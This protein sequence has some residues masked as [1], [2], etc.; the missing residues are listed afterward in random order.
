MLDGSVLV[1]GD[2]CRLLLVF[3]PFSDQEPKK[4]A[5]SRPYVQLTPPLE[6]LET[7]EN[8]IG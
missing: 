3:V 6:I 8:S 7:Y 1:M 4:L 2:E 5:Q